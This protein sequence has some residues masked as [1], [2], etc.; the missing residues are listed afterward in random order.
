M[1]GAAAQG[2]KKE[3]HQRGESKF[4]WKLSSIGPSL[5]GHSLEILPRAPETIDP[6]LTDRQTDRQTFRND[7]GNTS[8]SYQQQSNNSV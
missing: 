8:H 6:P 5:R 2:T 7:D 3:G 4:I 1:T